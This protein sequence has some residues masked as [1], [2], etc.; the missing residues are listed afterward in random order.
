[1]NSLTLIR[2]RVVNSKTSPDRGGRVPT[3]GRLGSDPSRAADFI[4]RAASD[5]GL[6]QT[7]IEAR[8]GNDDVFSSPARRAATSPRPRNPSVP[9]CR[10]TQGDGLWPEGQSQ[11]ARSSGEGQP[12]ARRVNV[13]SSRVSS[14]HGSPINA[15]DSGTFAPRCSPRSQPHVDPEH[16]LGLGPMLGPVRRPALPCSSSAFSRSGLRSSRLHHA[17]PRRRPRAGWSRRRVRGR[18]GATRAAR[19]REGQDSGPP[20][21]RGG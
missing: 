11:L 2:P 6:H 16:P 5:R 20:R 3:R 19:F 8:A 1:M 7:L 4:S 9:S 18:A 14:E 13:V 10:P 12:T 21:D 15:Q 17:A